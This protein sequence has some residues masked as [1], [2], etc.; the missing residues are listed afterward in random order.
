FAVPVFLFGSASLLAGLL[1]LK[2]PETN[3]RKLPETLEDAELFGKFISQKLVGTFQSRNGPLSANASA[4]KSEDEA[5][6]KEDGIAQDSS[7]EI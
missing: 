1:A 2:L 3:N 6:P 7:T 5:A 4:S